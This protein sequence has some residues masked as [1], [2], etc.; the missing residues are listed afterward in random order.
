MPR[1]RRRA[2]ATLGALTLTASLAWLA[3]LPASVAAYPDASSEPRPAAAASEAA[4]Q[5]TPADSLLADLV[6]R[7]REAAGLAA[8]AVDPGLAQVARAYAEEMVRTGFFSHIGKDG[9]TP[10]DRL[11]KAGIRFRAVYENLAGAPSAADAHAALMRSPGHRANILR[12][13]VARMGVAY[14]AGGPY[15]GFAV[16]LFL[17]PPDESEAAP[18]R[19]AGPAGP[20][21]DEAGR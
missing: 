18:E 4:W 12:A 6:N 17:V 7:S 21:Q 14:V 13:S 3:G 2:L 11:R 15:G 16:E 20:G 9:E 8:L 1:A 10:A 5:P 19:L